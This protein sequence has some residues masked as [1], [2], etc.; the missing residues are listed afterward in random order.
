M[1]EVGTNLPPHDM[2]A[3]CA[4][5]AAIFFQPSCFDDV[6]STIRFPEMFWRTSHQSIFRA[7]L[8]LSANNCEITFVT[9]ID[10]MDRAGVLDLNGGREQLMFYLRGLLEGMISVYGV[11]RWAEIVRER[12]QRRQLAADVHEIRELCFEPV[13]DTS[14]IIE[15]AEER[16]TSI[17]E[18][19]HTTA[20]VPVGDVA[21]EVALRRESM[22]E[23]QRTNS[24]KLPGLSTGLTGLDELM[25]GMKGA[26]LHLVAGRPG[27]GKTSLLLNLAHACWSE[28]V[29][30]REGGPLIFSLEMSKTEL[31]QRLVCSMAGVDSRLYKLGKLQG[32]ERDSA[33]DAESSLEDHL[34][35]VDDPN[36]SMTAVRS[37]A[38]RAKRKHNITAIYVDY[39]QLFEGEGKMDRHLV[40]GQFSRGLKKLAKELDVPV[41]AA[42]QLNRDVEKGVLRR[43][44]LSDLRES[45]SLEQDADTVTFI[46]KQ[47]ERDSEGNAQGD[48]DPCTLI[49]AKNR[50]GP[51]GD[52][53]CNF[54]RKHTKFTE[55]TYRH[56]N[57]PEAQ[58]SL[59][60]KKWMSAADY[61]NQ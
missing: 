43:P 47:T 54:H 15:L 51:V 4:V 35:I 9:V 49:V 12:W 14:T 5:I 33:I 24:N 38:R 39:I 36:L 21:A 32:A 55:V 34:W 53:K 20:V 27:D 25:T 59:P 50:N 48:C 60:P 57:E 3:E 13:E 7:V 41:I 16:I 46:Y 28:A 10:Q 2:E 61:S 22:E 42:A 6:A 8:I 56:E 44:R 18:A 45:G 31:I 19:V 52:V 17:S 37:L 58:R 40:I 1:S 11:E 23:F 30:T 29:E 26:E